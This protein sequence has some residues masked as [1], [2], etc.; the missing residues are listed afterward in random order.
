MKQNKKPQPEGTG[1]EGQPFNALRTIKPRME[2]KMSKCFQIS[3]LLAVIGLSSM[4]ALAQRNSGCGGRGYREAADQ[5][6]RRLMLKEGQVIA[7]VG[8][9]DGWWAKRMADKIGAQGVIH[10]AEISQKKVDTL[11]KNCVGTPQIKPR[12][13]PLDGTTLP[14]DSC[15]LAFISKTYH[16]F[17]K[18]GQV[19]YLRHLK[20]IIKPKGKLV[21]IELHSALATGR[22]KDHA[23]MPGLLARKAEEAGWMLLRCE[24]L[25]GSDHFMATFVQPESVIKKLARAQTNQKREQSQNPTSR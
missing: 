23:A 16:H 1:A 20:Q 25:R 8:A 15:D 22:G 2:D 3:M 17:D 9:G 12:L 24:L 7:D 5:V 6:I 10:A 14:E 21:I 4:P 19:D 13:I 18:D 11:K